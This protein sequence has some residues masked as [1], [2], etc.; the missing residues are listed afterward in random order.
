MSLAARVSGRGVFL[1]TGPFVFHVHSLMPV[2]S[3]GVALLYADHPVADE[4]EFADFRVSVGAGSKLRRVWRPQA[5]FRCDGFQPFKPLPASQALP[6]LEWGMNWAIAEHAH[7]FL[8]IHAAAV[9]RNGRVLILPGRSGSGKSTLCAALAHRGWRL[10]TDELTLVSLADGA[11]TPLVRPVSLKNE[12]IEVI[13]RFASASIS[14]ASEDTAKGTVALMKPPV[15][16]VERA[17]E[18]AIPAWIVF[19]TFALGEP[20][21]LETQSKAATFIE[22]ANNAF[23]YHTHGRRGFEVLAATID[24]CACLSLTYSDLDAAIALF[25]TLAEDA[26]AAA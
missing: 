18:K 17:C 9:E 25:D 2:V 26:R 23:N 8:I 14:R 19:P 13:R 22:L 21:R 3:E 15:A 16:S 1:R 10:L 24:R 20:I 11:I 4:A 6:F 5:I 12:S 7:Q